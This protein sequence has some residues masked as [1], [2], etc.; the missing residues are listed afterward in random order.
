M[1]MVSLEEELAMHIKIKNHMSLSSKNS[2]KLFIY[3]WKDREGGRREKEEAWGREMEEE[4]EGPSI[5]WFISQM[6]T[7]AWTE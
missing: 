3:F 1:V 7:T 4:A 5:R 6:P 2:I